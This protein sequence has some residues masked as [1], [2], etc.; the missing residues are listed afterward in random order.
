[1]A[2]DSAAVDNVI[3][4]V[5]VPEGI[6]STP[7]DTGR[8]FV[9]A[10]NHVIKNHGT[11]MTMLEDSEQRQIGC[12]WRMADVSRPL[13]SVTRIAGPEEGPGEYDVLFN[14]KKGVVVPPGT[15]ERILRSVTPI[16]EYP[17]KGGL[18]VAE[19]TLSGFARQGLQR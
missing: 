4:P 14:N 16:T 17:R 6:P 1:M 10:G 11:C 13:H 18:Y 9:D 15:V 5:E 3:H 2:L 19:M 7:N 12:Q 8:D